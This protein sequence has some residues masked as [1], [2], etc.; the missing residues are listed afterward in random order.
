MSIHSDHV[1]PLHEREASTNSPEDKSDKSPI[2]KEGVVDELDPHKIRGYVN[3][4]IGSE[5]RKRM[6]FDSSIEKSVYMSIRR[7]NEAFQSPDIKA[8]IDHDE[9]ESANGDIRI[10]VQDGFETL[11]ELVEYEDR[12]RAIVR[13]AEENDVPIIYTSVE[14]KNAG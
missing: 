5:L 11:D 13:T 2:S 10:V 6:A 9:S 3:A 7:L 8:I 4:T 1:K 12:V 14:R